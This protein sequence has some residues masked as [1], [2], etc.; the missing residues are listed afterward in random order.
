[1]L[2]TLATHA[3]VVAE[4]MDLSSTNSIDNQTHLM[5]TP[6]SLGHTT[7]FVSYFFTNPHVYFTITKIYTYL[8]TSQC[9]VLQNKSSATIH[10]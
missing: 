2:A 8:V 9:C 6:R 10:L 3:Q 4:N 5:K 7:E 1:M